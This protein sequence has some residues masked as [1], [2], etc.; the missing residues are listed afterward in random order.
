MNPRNRT[1]EKEKGEKVPLKPANSQRF[2]MAPSIE[3]RLPLII[4]I[5]LY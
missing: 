2:F 5:K 3:N 4:K 1:L